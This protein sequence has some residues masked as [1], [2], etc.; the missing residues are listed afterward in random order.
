M[1]GR[2]P[3]KTARNEGDPM[4]T[5]NRRGFT[6]IELCMAMASIVI[7]MFAACQMLLSSARDFY[8]SEN[9]INL[10]NKIT[11]MT[12]LIETEFVLTSGNFLPPWLSLKV[13][14]SCGPRIGLPDCFQSD[15]VTIATGLYDSASFAFF[16]T[17]S[18]ASFDNITN[19]I[20]INFALPMLPCPIN[21]S[22]LNQHILLTNAMQTEVYSLW[23]SNLNLV[24]CTFSVTPDLQGSILNSTNFLTTNY[25]S[26]VVS[27]V[28][29]RSYFIDNTAHTLTY[30]QK[31]TNAAV[32][33]AS[34]FHDVIRDVYDFQVALG[35]D[36][37]PHDGQILNLGSAT[38]EILFNAPADSLAT[39]GVSG[40]IATDLRQMSIA[41]VMGETIK[42]LSS[43]KPK[44][45]K[46]FDGPVIDIPG[47]NLQSIERKMFFRNAMA[48]L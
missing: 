48:Y 47:I 16:T 7:T 44:T 11:L 17:P 15:R 4:I 14:D 10:S 13:E 28:R 2:Q 3:L 35:Y 29:L 8:F 41:V 45:F 32:H 21:A 26:G 12:R 24:T 31:S 36:T 46:N 1:D 34:E 25:S 9:Q 30:L 20:F 22:H 37:A 23:T 38:D 40:A 33:L 39:M 18:V 5:T 6:L 42:G 27:F 19:T 43:I